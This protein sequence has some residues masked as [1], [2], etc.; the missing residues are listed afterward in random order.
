MN[1]TQAWELIGQL[2]SWLWNKITTFEIF[3]I[4]MWPYAIF[5]IALYFAGYLAIKIIQRKGATD[6]DSD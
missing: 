4:L 6:G 2:A 5:S 3:G 1:E